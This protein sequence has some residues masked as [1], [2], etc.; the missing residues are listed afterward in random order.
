MSEHEDGYGAGRQAGLAIITDSTGPK[1]A[2]RVLAGYRKNA[3]GIMALCHEPP[4]SEEYRAGYTDGF[5]EEVLEN[6][7][8][9]AGAAR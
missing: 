6:A 5:W 1:E 2:R 7:E 3:P 9:L 8:Y 4:G